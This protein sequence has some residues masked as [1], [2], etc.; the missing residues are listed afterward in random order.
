MKKII[1]LA[2]A[3]LLSVSF[4]IAA[5]AV[6]VENTYFYGDVEVVFAEDSSF[7][8]EMK[9]HIADYIVNG[10]DGATTYNLMCTLFGHKETS[11]VVLT[12]SHKVRATNPRCLQQMWEIHACSR[13]NEALDQILLSETYID[14]CPEG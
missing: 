7:S 10:D 14:C 4:C 9:Q 2:L 11:E 13:C 3:L 6:D 1:S 12:T 5:S 8:E